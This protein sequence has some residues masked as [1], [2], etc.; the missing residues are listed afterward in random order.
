M[1]EAAKNEE[2]ERL[3]A[4]IYKEIKSAQIAIEKIKQEILEKEQQFGANSMPA[5]GESSPPILPYESWTKK[6]AFVCA[7]AW[8]RAL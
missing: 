1:N 3:A 5:I 2:K 7:R 6:Q 4:T 8:I